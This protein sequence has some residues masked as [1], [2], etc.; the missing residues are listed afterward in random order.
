[1]TTQHRMPASHQTSELSLAPW[2]LLFT[3]KSLFLSEYAE[4]EKLGFT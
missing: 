4:K 3:T 1:M 2:Q